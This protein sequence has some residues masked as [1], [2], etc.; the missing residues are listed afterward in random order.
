MSKSTESY[1]ES[2]L[3]PKASDPV[4]GSQ[5]KDF[6]YAFVGD[7]DD[8]VSEKDLKDLIGRWRDVDDVR[9]STE[10][11]LPEEVKGDT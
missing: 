11:K 10:N 8:Q 6:T 5:R 3:G 4:P 1:W 9:A 7:H 2:I